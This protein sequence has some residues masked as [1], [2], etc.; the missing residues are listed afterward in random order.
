MATSSNSNI[1]SKMWNK[2]VVQFF[3]YLYIPSLCL[4]LIQWWY[5]VLLPLKYLLQL[6]CSCLGYVHWA[7]HIVLYNKNNRCPR[8]QWDVTRRCWPNGFR[9]FKGTSGNHPTTL[10]HIPENFNPQL[11][12][13]ENFEPHNL[14]LLP[15]HVPLHNI[16]SIWNTCPQDSNS[17]LSSPVFIKLLMLRKI[18]WLN[19]HLCTQHFRLQ[20]RYNGVPNVHLGTLQG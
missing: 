2:T 9:R 5:I 19:T 11:H 13:C 14:R 16:C 7:R 4:F 12:C 17:T 15:T 1:L 3:F 8:F 18:L 20:L 6:L 10:G